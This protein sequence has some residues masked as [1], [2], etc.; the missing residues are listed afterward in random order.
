MNYIIYTDGIGKVTEKSFQIRLD[1]DLIWLPK[2]KTRAQVSQKDG[3]N[4]Y[5]VIVPYWLASEKGF[6]AKSHN[7][8]NLYQIHETEEQI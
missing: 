1:H 6:F 2:S 3:F 5:R 8:I 4:Q 7:G